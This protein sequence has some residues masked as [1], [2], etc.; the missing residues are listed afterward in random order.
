M[1]IV[2]NDNILNRSP[3]DLN[4]K[5]GVFEAGVW[6]PYLSTSEALANPKLNIAY[7]N[8]GLTIYIEKNGTLTEY[9]WRDGIADNQLI[10]KIVTS[11]DVRTSLIYSTLEDAPTTNIILAIELIDCDLSF[12]VAHRGVGTSLKGTDTTPTDETVQVDNTTG[13]VTF[14]Y[15]FTDFEEKIW[16]EYKLKATSVIPSD[17]FFPYDFPMDFDN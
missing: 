8:R 3:K 5:T 14:L 10:E 7:R 4:D 15:P 1:A 16:F 11:G 6:R 12:F 13:E 9:W 17:D 2:L